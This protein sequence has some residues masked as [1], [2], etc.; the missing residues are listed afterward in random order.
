MGT[1]VR[2]V[3][4]IAVIAAAIFGMGYYKYMDSK[5]YYNSG[6]VNG[7]T[8]GNLYGKG[9]FCESNGVVYFANPN[10]NN[11]L[12]R[13]NPDE[14]EVTKVLEDRVFYINADDHYLFY[15]RDRSSGNTDMSFLNVNVTSLCR[16]TLDGKKT[17]ILDDTVCT[18][19]ALDGNTV[20]YFRY[21]EDTGTVL[22]AVDIDGEDKRQLSAEP[23][24]PSCMVGERMYYSGVSNDHHLYVK[25]V[26]TNTDSNVLLEDTWMPTVVGDTIYFID[27]SE[28][29]RISK[30]NLNDGTKT[31]ISQYPAQ[32]YNLTGNTIYYMSL[33]AD[34]D[35][36][37]KLDVSGGTEELLMQGQFNSINVTSR[38]VYFYDYFSGSC[39]H[40]SLSGGLPSTFSPEIE[41]DKK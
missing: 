28:G 19:A 30:V 7:N 17:A 14:T 8:V 36:M 37:Y 26:G 15:S 5:I 20:V 6:A 22:Y 33:E 34:T 21:T 18:N 38:Y 23:L 13:M 2:R 3:I 1:V 39:L 35:G 10:D 27:L 12:Y 29:H 16:A 4:I 9:L 41:L 32:E 31:V 25:D 11:A 24:D 40:C